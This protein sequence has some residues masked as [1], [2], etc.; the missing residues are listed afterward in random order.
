MNQSYDMISKH[1]NIVYAVS[2]ISVLYFHFL[3]IQK[4]AGIQLNWINRVYDRYV[5]SIGVEMFVFLSGMGLYRSMSKSMLREFW[6]KR[7][8]RILIPY[9]LVGVTVY[10]WLDLCQMKSISL[11]F[12]DFFWINYIQNGVN[13]FWYVLFILLMYLVYPLIYHLL[14]KE[15]PL[16]YTCLM[17]IGTLILNEVLYWTCGDFWSHTSILFARVP[18]FLIGCCVGVYVSKKRKI[19]IPAVSLYIVVSIFLK[20]AVMHGADLPA[21]WERYVSGIYGIGLCMALVLAAEYVLRFQ[22]MEWLWDKIE[23]YT[24]ELYLWNVGLWA[25]LPAFGVNLADPKGYALLV[26]ADIVLSIVVHGIYNRIRTKVVRI[27]AI[28]P[29]NGEGNIAETGCEKNRGFWGKQEH[30]GYLYLFIKSEN[31]KSCLLFFLAYI[32]WVS[33]ALIRYTYF[34]DLFA[35]KEMMQEMRYIVMAILLLKF[36]YDR[37]YERTCLKRN[38]IGI[39]VIVLCLVIEW[40]TE[41]TTVPIV[42]LSLFIFSANNI[43]F[44][45]ILRVSLVISVCVMVAAVSC[46]C[47]GVI[48]N[49]TW[50]NAVRIRRDFGFTYCTFG[51]HLMLFIT[52]EYVCIRKQLCWV[53]GAVLLGLNCLWYRGT[54]TRLDFLIVIP[55]VAV[56]CVWPCLSGRIPKNILT[57][58]I[59]QYGGVLIAIFSICMQWLYNP[60]IRMIEDIN[61]IFSLRLQLGHEAIQQYGI[62]LFGQHIKWVG[63]GGKTKHPEWVYNYVDCSY[64]KY[65]L[66]YGLIFFIVLMLALVW[67][68]KQALDEQNQMLCIS[69]IALFVFAMVDAELCVLAFHPFLLSAGSFFCEESAKNCPYAF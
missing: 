20:Y 66:N 61:Q 57:K 33:L 40:H 37:R 49:H 11:F 41:D 30:T 1:R 53:E 55:F 39:A 63:V 46:S 28:K 17:M 7:A 60:D 25:L 5:S 6:K 45:D 43:E 10:G 12:K 29:E 26:V 21:H 69:Y 8:L 38:L 35:S 32:P 51:S 14:E 3:C 31:K 65:L 62:R 64:L 67:I 36:V 18:V 44:D 19:N 15:D 22:W 2:I 16:F 23:P 4:G 50:E 42:I 9:C 52:M 47:F 27:Q 48:P 58:L 56:C 34:K 13:T 68:G 59:F 54:L 24:F